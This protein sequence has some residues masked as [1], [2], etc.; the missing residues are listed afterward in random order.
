MFTTYGLPPR[1]YVIFYDLN[2]IT[3]EVIYCGLLFSGRLIG[4]LYISIKFEKVK[5]ENVI[6]DM[7]IKAV[8]GY[9]SI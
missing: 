5:I 9:N 1:L 4:R 3:Q 8:F 7:E 2:R 6:M